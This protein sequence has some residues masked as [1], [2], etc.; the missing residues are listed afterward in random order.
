[1]PRNDLS[2][3]QVAA[4]NDYL[5]RLLEHRLHDLRSHER[6]VESGDPLAIHLARRRAQRRAASRATQVRHWKKTPK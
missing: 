2:E 6:A 5:D 3:R 4:L 1:V